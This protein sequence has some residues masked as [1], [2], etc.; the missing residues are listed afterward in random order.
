M[1]PAN[2]CLLASVL[3]GSGGIVQADTIRVPAD[4]PTIAAALEASQ[5][6]DTI[7]I[8]A[9]TY[10]EAELM[11]R[12]GQLLITGE[13]DAMGNP[14]VTVDA[15]NSAVN[16]TFGFGIVGSEG[17]TLENLILTGSTGNAVWI[18]HHAPTIRNCV[19]TG[20]TSTA[21]GVAVWSMSSEAIFEN[22]RFRNNNG[23]P[24]A[25][26]FS[27]GVDDGEY[28]P[29]IRNST[30]CENGE[31]AIDIWGTWT[32]GGNNRFDESCTPDCPAD[33]NGDLMVDGADLSVILGFWGDCIVDDCHADLD[34]NGSVD[35]ADLTIALGSWGGC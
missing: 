7:S 1:S 28:G 10:Y 16:I 5:D 23:G 18:Y 32:D 6:G 26:F 8:A 20:N 31:D 21:N 4:Q 13:T 15:S 30:F 17:A 14:L 25:I 34:G 12:T 2:Q 35:G 9:G 22:C 33:L 19:F 11:P 24:G 29:T 3:I 27:G